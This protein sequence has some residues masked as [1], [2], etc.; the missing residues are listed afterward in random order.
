MADEADQAQFI[1]ERDRKLALQVRRP[2]L[3]V[4]GECHYCGETIRAPRLFCES[5]CRDD[6]EREQEARRRSGR[7][8]S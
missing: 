6:Y 1:E 7:G 5:G 8:A 4:T 3:P 2:E